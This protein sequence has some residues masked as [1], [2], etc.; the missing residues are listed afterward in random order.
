MQA[1]HRG[2]HLLAL[3]GSLGQSP[4]V[5]GLQKV[6]FPW[7]AIQG[8][9]FLLQLVPG[10]LVEPR[11]RVV[12]TPVGSSLLAAP[13]QPAATYVPWNSADNGHAGTQPATP[14]LH[15]L[16]GDWLDASNDP[17]PGSGEPSGGGCPSDTSSFAST[18]PVPG[19]LSAECACKP[20]I[21]MASNR[22]GSTACR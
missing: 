4:N 8:V 7:P 17:N 11:S 3:L 2:A 20:R 19:E 5:A 6:S 14:T 1:P 12:A 10:V 18:Q 22:I 9:P 21:S 15:Q 16:P 13:S